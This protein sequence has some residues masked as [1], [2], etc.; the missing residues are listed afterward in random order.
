M[1]DDKKVS[2][3]F[4]TT[5]LMP[6]F[7]RK[8]CFQNFRTWKCDAVCGV[9]LC[10]TVASNN[11]AM[12]TSVIL[13]NTTK[14]NYIYLYWLAHLQTT[15]HYSMWIMKFPEIFLENVHRKCGIKWDFNEKNLMSAFCDLCVGLKGW[16]IWAH[17]P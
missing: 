16:R 4:V 15:S 11:R 12:L 2:I 8:N 7:R 10:F 1:A 9:R 14:T 6:T 3:T 17:Q 5:H 13:W